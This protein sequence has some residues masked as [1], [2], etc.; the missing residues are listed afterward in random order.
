MGITLEPVLMS[1]SLLR[2]AMLALQRLADEFQ[3][4]ICV[5]LPNNQ[6]Q[7]RTLHIQ[8]KVLPYALC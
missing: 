4:E 7:H 1:C 5:L 2:G 6:R 3:R 8:K